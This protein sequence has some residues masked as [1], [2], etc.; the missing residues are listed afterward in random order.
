MSPRSHGSQ[1]VLSA[2][3]N[4]LAERAC[5]GPALQEVRARSR[6][7]GVPSAQEDLEEVVDHLVGGLERAPRKT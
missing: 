6:A 3:P 2:A 1:P 7:T 4:L 5:A